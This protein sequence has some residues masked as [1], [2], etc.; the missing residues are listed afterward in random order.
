VVKLDDALSNL[1]GAE[2]ARL[3]LFDD[4]LGKAVQIIPIRHVSKAPGS[5]RLKLK[6]DEL[7]SNVG[8]EFNLRRYT[9]EHGVCTGTAPPTA[10]KLQTRLGR[11]LRRHRNGLR[12]SSRRWTL[13]GVWQGMTRWCAW[14]GGTSWTSST[15]RRFQPRCCF[16]T[17]RPGRC[18]LPRFRIRFNEGSTCAV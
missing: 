9:W 10:P 4:D 2:M 6:Y 16:L 1:S 5:K 11:R 7:H 15:C 12:S 8:S 3:A 17:V 18:H 14:M 13:T